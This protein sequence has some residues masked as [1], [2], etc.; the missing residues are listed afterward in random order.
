MWEKTEC[1]LQCDLLTSKFT[2]QIPTRTVGYVP[3][4][5]CFLLVRALTKRIKLWEPGHLL[6]TCHFDLIGWN[7][8]LYLGTSVSSLLSFLVPS[9]VMLS[10]DDVEDVYLWLMARSLV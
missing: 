8:H 3:A 4:L 6:V 1:L 5:L 2:T 9:S 10:R 7:V